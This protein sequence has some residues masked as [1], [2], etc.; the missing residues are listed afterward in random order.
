M[1]PDVLVNTAVVDDLR[2][3]LH[4]AHSSGLGPY[5]SGQGRSR[6]SDRRLGSLSHGCC[7]GGQQGTVRFSMLRLL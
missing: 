5:P 6:R 7:G 4:R 1:Q 3:I 2:R